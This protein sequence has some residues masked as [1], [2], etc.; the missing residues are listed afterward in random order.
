[1]SKILKMCKI[2]RWNLYDEL[3]V[4]AMNRVVIIVTSV[5]IVTVN[6]KFTYPMN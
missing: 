3:L 1:M 5:T 2:S 6:S 4:S